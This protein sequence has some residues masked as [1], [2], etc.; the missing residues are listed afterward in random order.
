[1]GELL[2]MSKRFEISEVFSG[3]DIIWENRDLQK[4]DPDLAPSFVDRI[5]K[6]EVWFIGKVY[7][8]TSRFL[9]K[10]VDLCENGLQSDAS[11][12][13]AFER[14]CFV[15]SDPGDSRTVLMEAV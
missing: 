6:M 15:N 12:F 9:S 1:M 13:M 5:K 3:I 11:N 8:D 7:I 14:F 10:V 4:K 2:L